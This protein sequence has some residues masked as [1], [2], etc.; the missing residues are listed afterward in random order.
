MY[1]RLTQNSFKFFGGFVF[2]S[3]RNI[4]LDCANLTGSVLSTLAS[5]WW[6]FFLLVCLFVLIKSSKRI[7]INTATKRALKWGSLLSLKVIRPKRPKI[8]PLKVVEFYRRLF[9]QGT[10]TWIPTIQTSVKFRDFA[11]LYP[12]QFSTIRFQT[13][14]LTDFKAFS[15]TASLNLKKVLF[16][17]LSICISRLNL[18]A[19]FLF[20]HLEHKPWWLL[21]P[22]PQL[23]PLYGGSSLAAYGLFRQNRTLQKKIATW[24]YEENCSGIWYVSRLIHSGFWN[25]LVL[26]LFLFPIFFKYNL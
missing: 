15:P 19:A 7:Y 26:N 2:S 10:L 12:R 6:T 24:R 3:S 16:S 18:F 21:V 25:I 22:N 17:K 1:W 11:K 5:V 23:C 13:W 9:D 20:V 8:W 4:F 14:Q